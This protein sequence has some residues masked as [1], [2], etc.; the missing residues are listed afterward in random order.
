MPASVKGGIELRKALKKFTPDLAK[1]TQKQLGQ[2][3]RPVTSKARGYIP[4][5]APLSGWGKPSLTGRFPEWSTQDAKRG[6]GYKTTPSKPNRQGWRSLARIVNASA[7]G[8]IYETAGRVNPNGRAQNEMV[9]VVAP[10]NA[11]YGKMIRGSDKT[12]S[13]SNNPG[14]GNMF[15][16]AINQYGDIVD[17]RTLG[18]KGRPSRKFRGRAIFR[19]WKEDGGKTNAAVLKSIQDA[20]DKFYKAVGYN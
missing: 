3:L 9:Q 18:T 19:A 7:A 8:T 14:A 11:N 12:K 16:E 15:I 1:E 17:A 5:S 4:S 2:L 20:Q 10:S 6:I 13:R